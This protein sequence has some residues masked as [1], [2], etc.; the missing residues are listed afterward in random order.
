MGGEVPHAGGGDGAQ[1]EAG[2]VDLVHVPVEHGELRPRLPRERAGPPGAG[3]VLLQAQGA[4]RPAVVIRPGA[5]EQ[6][7]N[8][9]THLEGEPSLGTVQRNRDT[10]VLAALSLSR[11][12][13]DTLLFLQE[14]AGRREPGL[15]LGGEDLRNAGFCSRQ[16]LF[17]LT[18]RA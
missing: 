2:S 14:S 1:E 11:G 5:Q 8:A 10:K 4:A 9:P 12:Q 3:A 13:Q 7:L 6:V 15:E 18:H 16:G 17:V